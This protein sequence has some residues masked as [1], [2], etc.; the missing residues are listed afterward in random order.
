MIHSFCAQKNCRDGNTPSSL[1]IDMSGNLYGTTEYGG[2]NFNDEGEGLVFELKSNADRSTWHF[3][4]LYEF[5]NR[6]LCDTGCFPNALT[7]AGAQSGAPYDGTSSLYGTTLGGGGHQSGGGLVFQLTPGRTWREKVVYL[8]CS[9]WDGTDCIDGNGPDGIAADTLGNIFGVTVGGGLKKN[10]YAGTAFQLSPSGRKWV[11][12]VL[13]DFCAVSHCADGANPVGIALD[14]AGNLIGTAA[15][16][17]NGIGQTAGVIYQLAPNGSQSSYAVKYNFCSEQD[18]AD[19]NNPGAAVVLDGDGNIYGTTRNGG[20][21][22]TDKQR[23]GG[24]VVS[25]SVRLSKR[26]T[27]SAQKLI[28]RTVSIPPKLF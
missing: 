14:S 25:N 23:Q 12:S 26:C 13:Y 4:S 11:H 9:E 18:C 7:Y 5:G 22:D 3:T 15:G 8:F 21:H 2:K 16:G 20:G 28:A 27:A 24:G 1:L 19:G 10:K 6:G 17:V